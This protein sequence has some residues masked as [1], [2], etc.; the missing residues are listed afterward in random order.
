MQQNTI[1]FIIMLSSLNFSCHRKAER[2]VSSNENQS[3]EFEP[4][5]QTLVNE[6]GEHLSMT[7]DHEKEMVSVLFRGQIIEMKRMPAASGIRYKNASFQLRGKGDKIKLS[8]N[9]KLIFESK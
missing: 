8:E 3:E 4:A 2:C 7:F 6:K 1:L 9:G 5:R